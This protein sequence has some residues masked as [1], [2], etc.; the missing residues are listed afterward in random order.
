[1][2][3]ILFV[4][5]LPPK[6]IHGVSN[7]NDMNIKILSLYFNIYTI[8]EYNP[9]TT[10]N[11]SSFSKIEQILSITKKLIK[12]VKST[13]IDFLYTNMAISYFGMLKNLLFLYS[14]KK[15]SKGLA[16]FHV[17]R[18][19]FEKFYNHSFVSKKL[20]DYFIK[21]VDKLIFLSLPLI[22]TFLKGTEK[23]TYLQNT[24]VPEKKYNLLPN[25]KESFLYLSNYIE[26]KGIL[27][28]LSVFQ[29]ICYNKLLLNCFGSF[30]DEALTKK[31]KSY[32]SLSIKINNAL[33]KN[34]FEVINR[35]D[36]L[37]LPSHNEGQPLIILEAMMCGT[38]IIASEVG[39][40]KNMLGI[41]YPF[42]FQA[43]NLEDLERV[44]YL[45]LNTNEE[46]LTDLS[47]YLQKRYFEL[48]SNE[49]HKRGLLK[50]FDYEG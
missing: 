50:I 39:D 38:I 16:I 35:A 25:R 27:D 37:I 17:H 31:I 29:R 32:E 12:L 14:Y 8:E 43:K 7:S 48:Y 3:N 40:V 13:K 28:I 20:V 9:L 18:G 47:E 15:R 45:Y 22:P 44:I 33:T 23:A 2:K 26:T 46:T 36:V 24:I 21:K 6:T 1:M 34:K 49:S 5:E 10:H 4:G 41:D 11:K 19:D 42:L 30:T